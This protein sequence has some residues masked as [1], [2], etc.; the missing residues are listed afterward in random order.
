MAMHLSS[1]HYERRRLESHVENRTVYAVRSA[2]LNVYETHQY[3][4]KVD[5]CS[6]ARFWQV[7]CGE[8]R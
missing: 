3:A 2:D 4:E 1:S 8:R 5:W 7:C 6:I